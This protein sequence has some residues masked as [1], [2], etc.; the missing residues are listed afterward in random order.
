MHSQA[1]I[2]TISY[3]IIKNFNI[4]LIIWTLL[5]CKT[6][7]DAEILFENHLPKSDQVVL[8]KI[9]NSY[10][11]LIKKSMQVFPQILLIELQ[12]T[13][14]LSTHPKCYTTASL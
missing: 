14:R 10:D 3:E 11:N 8:T 2:R 7:N 4:L 12:Q 5:G 9:I 1:N 13:N 6:R